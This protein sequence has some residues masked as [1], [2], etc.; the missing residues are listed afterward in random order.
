MRKTKKSV[1]VLLTFVTVLALV[2][3]FFTACGEQTPPAPQETEILVGYDISGV[4]VKSDGKADITYGTSVFKA[5]EYTDG[6]YTMKYRVYTPE[7][8]GTSDKDYPVLMF[9]HGAGERGNDNVKQISTYTGFEYMFTSDAD[10]P[11]LDAIVIAPQC[12]SNEQWVNVSAWT[13]CEYSTDDIA[14]SEALEAA[15]KLLKYY[16]ENERVNEN[17]IYSMGLSM[18]GYATWDIA[19]R[20][21]ELLAAIAPICG[22]CDTSKSALLADMPVYTFH[23]SADGT[24]PP[25]GTRNM[26]EALREA[27]NENVKYVEYEG[28]RHNIWNTAM[29]SDVITWLFSNVKTN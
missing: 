3:A 15:L 5:M 25:T 9:F 24:V 18:G 21:N 12:P 7:D 17:A 1:I 6:D 22:G 14:E 2:C 16:A 19:V 4:S 27:G 23:G 13:E 11:V 8:Y 28:Q 20:H 26:V 29:E 10:S